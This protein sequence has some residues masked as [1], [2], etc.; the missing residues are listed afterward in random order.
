V[1]A[2]GVLSVEPTDK[3]RIEVTFYNPDG[4]RAF[5]GNGLRCAAS[6]AFLRGYA[7]KRMILQTS[8]G[9]IPAEILEEDVRL[10]LPPPEDRGALTLEV[11]GDVLEGRNILAGVPHYV[12]FVPAV[13]HAPLEVWGPAVRSDEAF[14]PEGTNLDVVS[15]D[16]NGGL[17][18]RT[19]ERGV[20]GETLSCGTGAVAAALAAGI[21]TADFSFRIFPRSGM[22]LMV[23][24]EG[25]AD[26]P[27]SAIL[28]GNARVVFE[29][30]MSR[31]HIMKQTSGLP[32]RLSDSF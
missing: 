5:C 29:G 6:F 30:R 8:G 13:D 21:K 11:V 28:E 14:G 22:P 31:E 10:I 15:W 18:L 23:T 7:G 1:G 16:Q 17:R 9:R 24:L 27:T 20:E 26:V 2:D 3:D 12:V 25:S 32:D 4:S 19:W